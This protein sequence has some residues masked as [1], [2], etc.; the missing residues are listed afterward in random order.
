LLYIAIDRVLARRFFELDVYIDRV[1]FAD[2]GI[3]APVFSGILV[4]CLTVTSIDVFA[5]VLAVLAVLA[6]TQKVVLGIY[7]F[8]LNF[9]RY[10]VA[11][12]AV[13]V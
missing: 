7:F 13:V 8:V 5:C 4:W 10:D 3:R 2:T 9:Y 6:V 1:V 12:V 11:V